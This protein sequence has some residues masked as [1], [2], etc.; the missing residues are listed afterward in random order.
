MPARDG[1]H[2]RGPKGPGERRGGDGPQNR[3]QRKSPARCAGLFVGGQPLPRSG[4]IL[5]VQGHTGWEL[6][7]SPSRRCA[8]MLSPDRASAGVRATTRMQAHRGTGARQASI[9]RCS[10]P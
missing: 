1:S 3:L 9:G 6:R 4:E 8:A 5:V 10:R 7:Y 2:A